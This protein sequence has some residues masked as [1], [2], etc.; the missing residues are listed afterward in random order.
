MGPALIGRRGPRKPTEQGHRSSD[1]LAR[2]GEVWE[3]F[4]VL[5][6]PPVH[7]VGRSVRTPTVFLTLN[8]S[9]KLRMFLLELEPC[10]VN[11][12]VPGLHLLNS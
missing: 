12:L 8:L 1:V 7:I 9:L 5:D 3:G 11:L 6:D 4:I 10:F 2:P